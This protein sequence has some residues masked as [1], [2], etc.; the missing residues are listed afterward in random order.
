MVFTSP[1]PAPFL[2]SKIPDSI[3]IAD[4]LLEERWGRHAITQSREPFV[5]GLTGKAYSVD[6]VKQRVEYLARGLSKGLGWSPGGQDEQ[7]A[8]NRVAAVFSFNSVR[9]LSALSFASTV[10][11]TDLD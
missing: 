11:L 6:T 3:Q 7:D 1:S 4:F 5:C 10:Q 2:D 8:W 9:S